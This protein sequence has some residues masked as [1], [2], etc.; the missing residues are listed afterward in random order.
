[1]DSEL[2]ALRNEL[3]LIEQ[4]FSRR[5]KNLGQSIDDIEEKGMQPSPVDN[6]SERVE[7]TT[8]RKSSVLDAVMS[9]SPNTDPMAEVFSTSVSDDAPPK[10]D[11]RS[12]TAPIEK[13]SQYTQ[14]TEKELNGLSLTTILLA[15]LGPFA[16]LLEKV[17]SIYLHYKEQGKAPVFFMTTSGIV[18]LV[19]G[20]T[21]LL[22]YSFNEYLGEAGKVAIGFALA[23]ATTA[24]GIRFTKKRESMAEY[25]SSLIALGVVLN[26]L[27]V[28]FA[29]PYYDLL[30]D[31]VTFI[32]FVSVTAGAYVLALQFETKIVATV[33]LLGGAFMPLVTGYGEQSPELYLSYLLVLAIVVL[34]L[35]Q[36]I[37]WQ[38]LGSA[39]VLISI[40]M[41]EFSITDS[42]TI[43]YETYGLL[44]IIHGFFYAFA[45]YALRG[46]DSSSGITSQRLIIATANLIF[47]LY[48]SQQL[49]MD[50]RLLGIVYLLNTLPWLLCFIKP[51]KFFH[52]SFGSEEYSAVQSLSILHVGLIAGVGI[53]VLS[54][55]EM[56]GILWSVEGL[57]LLYLGGIYKFTSVR[58]E[59]YIA[60]AI[61]LI[62]M[63]NQ[64]VLWLSSVSINAPELMS[65]GMGF[66]W[67]N[68][69]S[70]TTLLYIAIMLLKR[71]ATILTAQEKA[72]ISPLDNLFSVFI[73][74][75][76]LLTVGIISVQSMWLCAIIPMF[77]LIWRAQVR[78]LIFTELL[79]LACFLLMVVPILVSAGIVG[80]FHF[81]EQNIY[82][83]IA[84]VEVFL[85]LWLIAEFYKRYC[86]LSPNAA[87]AKG[88]RKV[89]YCLIP[90]LFLPSVLRQH[91]DYFPLA[92]WLSSS[93][94][95]LLLMRL[96][97]TVL[98]VE[99][100]LL[101]F[102]SSAASIYACW[103]VEFDG[104]QGY[105]L[106]ALLVGIVFYLFIGWLGQGLR[107]EIIEPAKDIHLHD[108]LKPL[109]SV[110]VYYFA[111]AI[112][113]V[114]YG[115][116]YQ[117]G[118]SLLTTILYLTFV[119]FNQPILAPL[120]S[121]LRL[122]YSLIFGLTVLLTYDHAY[123]V[124]A[125]GTVN[126]QVLLLGVYNV[127]ALTCAAFLVYSARAQNRAVWSITGRQVVNIWLF[128]IIVVVA[129][130]SL[131]SQLFSAM[132]GP[133]ISFALVVHATVILF[134]TIKPRMKNLIW[135]SISLFA[136]AALKILLWD[137]QDFSLVQKIMVFMLVGL[138]MLGAAFKFQK[139]TIAQSS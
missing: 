98:Q 87:F 42:T 2:K 138:S 114:S 7:Q 83:Q 88:L 71:Q 19:L 110:A 139:I 99:L 120:R 68:L 57:M 38:H 66:G 56:T 94:A 129:Y 40:G 127:I 112:F 128:N 15:L 103:L 41:I 4:E 25:G 132:L 96:R 117:L 16:G 92:L 105:G 44:A 85:S 106:S 121:S 45:H 39:T 136:V 75:S 13:S 125:S 122:T 21:Y 63:G 118:F 107:R 28:Y 53:L 30:P 64:V 126:G 134:Q 5:I 36:R 26:Y 97:Y 69:L 74:L 43:S 55:L 76:F 135:L 18:A 27:C 113:I 46:F 70:I 1:M 32:L 24:G 123:S 89:F 133:V 35:S 90:V 59:G 67:F 91:S 115:L 12:S 54:S 100:R 22:Q 108:V 109:F 111:V 104:W 9:V 80:N 50:S 14:E 47:F 86:T 102:V 119:F 61:S 93:I 81:S 33:T 34:H 82:A 101:V 84:R 77:Y 20:F 49:I 52:Y 8:D 48:I 37:K 51:K 62:M 60:F 58:V 3:G 116:T 31:L 79:G 29:G 78:E 95:L 73:V 23:L 130:I 124:A 6:I 72:L 11:G 65:L 10:P 137:M 131:L 17:F